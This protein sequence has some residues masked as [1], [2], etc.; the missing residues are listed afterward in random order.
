MRK[1]F[2]IIFI[3]SGSLLFSQSQT[4]NFNDLTFLV[5]SMGNSVANEG[6]DVE[7]FY[8]IKLEKAITNFSKAYKRKEKKVWRVQIYFGTGRS[9]RASAK[10][11]K[12]NFEAAHPEV[13]SY[14]IF[15]EPYFKVRVGDFDTRLDAER[16]KLQIIEEYDKIFIVEDS[17]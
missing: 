10:S 6:G 14:L 16:L 12:K 4:K 17:Y 15:E 7:V 11:I 1:I 2:L 3:F 8:D 9:G 5:D 13:P